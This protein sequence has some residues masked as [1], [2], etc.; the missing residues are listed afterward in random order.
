MSKIKYLTEYYS[1]DFYKSITT[2]ALPLSLCPSDA[3]YVIANMTTDQK[4][5]LNAALKQ[6]AQV[7]NEAW[8]TNPVK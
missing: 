5:R 4:E 6:I 8:A 3:K 2:L 1:K 7:V